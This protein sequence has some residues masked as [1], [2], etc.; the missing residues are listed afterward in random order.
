[1]LSLFA[2]VMMVFAPVIGY[3]DQYRQIEK[4]K[5]SSGFSP[6]VSLILILANLLRIFFWFGKRF[7]TVMLYQSIVM[8]VAQFIMLQVCCKYPTQQQKGNSL[9]YGNNK[10]KWSAFWSWEDLT[11]YC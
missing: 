2:D 1:M 7:E 3:V 9:V 5:N 8:I 6:F 11:S 4:S 10:F